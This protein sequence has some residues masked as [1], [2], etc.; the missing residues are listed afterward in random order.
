MSF[1]RKDN[2]QLK[3]E[4]ESAVTENAEGAEAVSAEEMHDHAEKIRKHLV[5]SFAAVI[6]F[7][8]IIAGLIYMNRINRLDIKRRLEREYEMRSKDS[9]TLITGQYSGNTDFG[10][11][12]GEGRFDFNTGA[13]YSGN[14]N[15][16]MPDGLGELKVPFE[17]VYRGDFD[18]SHKNG[19]GVFIW[20]DGTVYD[21]EWKNDCMEGQGEYDDVSGVRYV[22]TFKVDTFFDGDCTFENETG[23][24]HLKY[25]DG[26]I[27][28][29]QIIFSDNSKYIG[30]AD[31]KAING[32]GVL[33]YANRDL[34]DGT[35]KEGKRN[36]S[37]SYRWITGNRYDGEWSNDLMNGTGAYLYADG[38]SLQGTFHDNSFT[39]GA[40]H[41]ESEFGDYTFSI[42]EGR[43]S[44]VKMKL[45]NGTEYEG[46][47]D[48]EGL[49]GH[50]QIRYDNGDKYD[51]AVRD[52]V[53]N[54][55]GAYF[56][57]SGAAYS[58]TWAN[59]QMNG[60]GIYR[61]PPDE[62][63]EKI[64]GSFKDGVPDGDCTY[65]LDASTYVLTTWSN[66]K[67]VK[68]TE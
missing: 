49:N 20:D 54:G 63:G 17:G 36:G 43:S 55:Q 29:A 37:G 3:R 62:E 47:M 11:F 32:H 16:N 66:G 65:Y 52:G 22:G 68:V 24:Y 25:K 23:S 46:D 67:C 15:E 53:K 64:E 39:D 10:Y 41:V 28:E 8:E 7:A 30:G 42:T 38:S 27:N 18:A 31:E 2:S 5:Y 50:A 12:F 34:Y 60:R 45:T 58:G 40:Y 19:K 59:D 51:G 33:A 4:N 61:Y 21:G 26:H 14:W 9:I 6:I 57:K 13:T 48:D 35:F 1:F 44:G 56:W